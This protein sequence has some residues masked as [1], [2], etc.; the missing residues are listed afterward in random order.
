MNNA[1]AK[2]QAFGEYVSPEKPLKELK[3][4]NKKS[5]I[6]NKK[7]ESEARFDQV[8]NEYMK[9]QQELIKKTSA[10]SKDFLKLI[11]DKTLDECKTPIVKDVE[12]EII[13]NL[14]N[15]S[16]V[17]NQDEQKPEGYG[18]VAMI[19]LLFKALLLQRDVVNKYA[20]EMSL[21]KK[22]IKDLEDKINQLSSSSAK[23]Q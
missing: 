14:V 5:S 15:I 11:I 3:L 18:S 2:R 6:P 16:L 12:K 8:A 17:V 4:K 1:P 13:N 9:E 19:N 23:Q 21:Q 22:Q 10:L 7:K 20:Y